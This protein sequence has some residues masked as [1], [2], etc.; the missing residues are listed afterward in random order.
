MKRL[1]MPCAT[2]LSLAVFADTTWTGLGPDNKWT[3]PGNWSDG[4]PTGAKGEKA[5][6]PSGDWTIR[7]DGT[8]NH[9]AFT[10]DE[11]AGRVTLTGDGMLQANPEASGSARSVNVKKGRELLIDG[12]TVSLY[13]YR[14]DGNVTLRHG[15]LKASTKGLYLYDGAELVVDG[16]FLDVLSGGNGLVLTNGSSV[17]VRGGTA[18]L[19]NATL[20]SGSA[21]TLL[22]GAVSMDGNLLSVSDDSS[23]RFLGGTNT[24]ANLSLDPDVNPE[25]V[26]PKGAVLNLTS[27]G[28][29][30]VNY[31]TPGDYE[32]AGTICA[33]NAKGSFLF[34]GCQD[35]S[36]VMHVTGRG[37][38]VVDRFRQSLSRTGSTVC[39][40]LAE[41][42][43]GNYGIS[44]ES[45][46]GSVRF[47]NGIRFSAFGDWEV[48]GTKSDSTYYLEGPVEF[49]TLDR[50]D[51]ATVHTISFTNVNL[52]AATALK[53]AGGGTVNLRSSA[54][55]ERLTSLEVAAGTRLSLLDGACAFRADKVTVG[56]AAELAFSPARGAVDAVGSAVVA[57]KMSVD[58]SGVSSGR[59]PVYF[60]PV[61]TDP[62]LDVFDVRNLPQ[63]YALAKRE[64]AVYLTDGTEDVNDVSSATT[65]E[66]YWK[67]S[68]DGNWRLSDNW[69]SDEAPTDSTTKNLNF[70]GWKN[71]VMDLGGNIRAK[72][73]I[74]HEGS[75]PVTISNGNLRVGN[76]N[77]ITSYSGYPVIFR[78]K[79]GIPN[80]STHSGYGLLVLSRGDGYIALA[81]GQMTDK[82]APTN[83]FR[84]VGDVR[85]GCSWAANDLNVG[86]GEHS[87]AN[88]MTLLPGA[89]L[90]VRCQVT[91]LAVPCSFDIAQGATLSLSGTALNFSG[92]G[93]DH[94]VDGVWT[95]NCPF[96]TSARQVFSGSGTIRFP[97]VADS[98]GGIE[99]RESVTFVP[100]TWDAVMPVFC[101]DTPT[102]RAEGD[103]SLFLGEDNALEL[104]PHA[105]LTV[106]AAE[107]DLTLESP[108]TG[109]GD[110]VKTGAGKL[111]FDCGG[112]VVDTLTIEAG[113]VDVGE[114]FRT[115]S[116]KPFLTAKRVVGEI[117]IDGMKVRAVDN[118]DGT[119]TY[120]AKQN[121][122]MI[123]IFR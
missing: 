56:A 90:T 38:L 89:E 52:S 28:N 23:F 94:C 100:G 91:D 58:L 7:I 92:S 36:E 105:R 1:L 122:G 61:G 76:A 118:G 10:I 82:N 88:R 24:V 96:S 37:S 115:S 39:F 97:S 65:D 15:S 117:K 55:P 14:Q 112:T 109:G 86:E 63:G 40:D 18:N 64:N 85:I 108:V 77:G 42:G 21:L 120:S 32:I 47:M 106:D 111:T 20:S 29:E 93:N 54:S 3:T 114:K 16:G 49:D 8:V 121:Q 72:G 2:F 44:C 119:M 33:T 80:A 98:A 19:R 67:G 43:L 69:S 83:D 25:L 46:T 6:V 26:P 113:S 103:I 12:P 73:V 75:G 48:F 107:G 60:A 22:D 13:S 27:G 78:S 99:L 41:L 4:V 31:K 30:A 123:L 11:G 102:I 70:K 53:V 35:P 62:D 104:E 110:L 5:F 79:M 17:V 84:F 50:F 74:V 57:G 87:R 68:A 95:V 59:T 45:H 81:G 66:W 71:T 116:Y 101:R 34:Y 51:K 9:Y